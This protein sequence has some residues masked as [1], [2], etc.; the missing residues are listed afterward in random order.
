MTAECVIWKYEL[1]PGLTVLD[2][3][4]GMQA[5]HVDVQGQ[6]GYL[7]AR[8]FT[9]IDGPVPNERRGFRVV[10]T[11]EK[12][13]PT[14]LGRYVGTLHFPSGLVFHVFEGSVPA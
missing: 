6:Y 4:V 5:L 8:V 9:D 11:G 14:E 13:R 1:R 7:W 2:M 10:A 12:V 3:P